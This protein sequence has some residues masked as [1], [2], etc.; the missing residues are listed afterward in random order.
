MTLKEWI[1]KRC[2]G[3]FDLV[4]DGRN[5][6]CIVRA[7][8]LNPEV[9]A[10]SHAGSY[11]F[12]I[13]NNTEG[14]SLKDAETR[15]LFEETGVEHSRSDYQRRLREANIFQHNIYGFQFADLPL[16]GRTKS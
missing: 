15:S 6:N 4:L 14:V 2:G 7:G 10:Q 16:S 3:D 13:F 12:G 1:E 9:L 5:Q 8:T 11:I